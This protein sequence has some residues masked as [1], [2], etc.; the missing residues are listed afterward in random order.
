[1]ERYLKTRL[2][3]E[4]S[5]FEGTYQLRSRESNQ[6]IVEKSSW[7]FFPALLRMPFFSN[8]VRRDSMPQMLRSAS[9]MTRFEQGP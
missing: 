8:L 1:V 6:T 7:S 4:N 2:L 5:A 9:D 3:E